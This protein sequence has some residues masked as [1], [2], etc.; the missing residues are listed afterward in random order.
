[1]SVGKSMNVEGSVEGI[2]LTRILR[3]RTGTEAEIRSGRACG[4]IRIVHVSSDHN[5]RRGSVVGEEKQDCVVPCS[6]FTNLAENPTDLLIHSVNHRRV[7]CHLG[8]LETFLFGCQSF[9]SNGKENFTVSKIAGN[10][11]ITVRRSNGIFP[12]RKFAG[13]DTGFC[14]PFVPLRADNI[15]TATSNGCPVL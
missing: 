4:C 15:P 13:N 7:N 11:I 5:F 8:R 10:R 3:Q 6:Y 2:S 9:S 12:N 1:M 14:Q